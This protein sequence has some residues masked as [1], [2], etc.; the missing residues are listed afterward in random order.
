MGLPFQILNIETQPDP[1]GGHGIEK[2]VTGRGGLGISR[3][4]HPQK[5]EQYGIFKIIFH[6]YEQ[7][8]VRA[9]QPARQ[10]IAIAGK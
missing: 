8:L 5:S 6:R 1:R 4:R 9:L 2:P 3:A 10:A 7:D